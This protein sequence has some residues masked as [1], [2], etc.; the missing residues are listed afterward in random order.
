MNINNEH[1]I[2]NKYEKKRALNIYKNISRTNISVK[3]S[4]KYTMDLYGISFKYIIF[5]FT[6]YNFKH[7]LEKEEKFI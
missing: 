2:G 1:N 5:H 7:W 6:I 3:R 4:Y